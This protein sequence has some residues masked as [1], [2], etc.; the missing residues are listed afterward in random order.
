MIMDNNIYN[1]INLCDITTVKNIVILEL[2]K[3]F[4]IPL[5]STKLN[6]NHI[7]DLVKNKALSSDKGGG[8]KEK[9]VAPICGE[10]ILPKESI[11]TQK[12]T[13]GPNLIN[14][15]EA[16]ATEVIMVDKLQ[17]DLSVN[18]VLTG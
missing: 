18:Y 16:P 6:Q 1:I 2:L 17:T 3:T 4:F 10:I 7:N 13:N 5:D 11:K 15:S 9:I 12:V 8:V 14:Q